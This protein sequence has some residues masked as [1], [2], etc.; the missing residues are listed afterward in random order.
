MRIQTLIALGQLLQMLNHDPRNRQAHDSLDRTLQQWQEE[1]RLSV[2]TTRMRLLEDAARHLDA[3]RLDGQPLKDAMAHTAQTEKQAQ[4]DRWHTHC[5]Q[6]TRERETGH[7]MV[8]ADLLLHILE[9]EPNHEEARRELTEVQSQ[10]REILDKVSDTPTKD[11]YILEGFYAFADGDYVAA[12]T[13]W[14]KAR[15]LFRQAASDPELTLFEHYEQIANDHVSE[16]LR[17]TESATFFQKG[18]ALYQAGRFAQASQAFRDA[19][20]RNPDYPQLAYYL[21]QSEAAEEKDRVHR[22]G[23]EKRKRVDDL[24]QTGLEKTEQSQYPAAE[25]AFQ[26]VL[27][28]D[29]AHP[30]AHSYL[31]L[32]QTELQRR[33]DPK[34]AQQH[35]EAGL[36]AYA[37]G[38]LEEALREWRMAVRMNAHH[39]KALNALNKVEKELAMNRDAL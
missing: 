39:E 7:F 6:A 31:L 37:S 23:E 13:A 17:N 21:T 5:E 18:L 35:Y 9:E 29:P 32:V 1:Q 30:Q 26:G 12:A 34:V 28:L 36:V 10:I 14:K 3:N 38:K 27:N 24:F 16:N 33:H 8:A 15:T 11:R 4:Q 20:I 19:A 2:K 22:L 25:K